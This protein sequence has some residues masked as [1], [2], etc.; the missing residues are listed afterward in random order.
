MQWGSTDRTNILLEAGADM[1]SEDN[2]GVPAI[3][4]AYQRDIREGGFG[5]EED[6][7]K[8]FLCLFVLAVRPLNLQDE[9][10]KAIYRAEVNAQDAT[11]MSPLHWAA[12][13]R[14]VSAVSVLLSAGAYVDIRSKR[15]KTPLFE[16]C[17]SNSK[18]CAELLLSY[19]ADVNARYKLGHAPIHA[20]AM[21]NSSRGLLE[22]LLSNGAD[23][24]DSQ[25]TC[26]TTPLN[27]AA[28][29]DH[30]R[31]C[32]HLLELGA[33]IENQDWLGETPLHETVS[34]NRHACLPLLL[35]RRP[36]Y[37]H[38]RSGDQTLLHVAAIK[39]DERT[40][41]IL[42][43]ANLK[44]LDPH[45]KDSRGMNARQY[46]AARSDPLPET[47]DSF[48][49]LIESLLRRNAEGDEN[50]LALERSDDEQF[51]DALERLC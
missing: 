21:G 47:K 17:F 19:G 24:N 6:K 27:E 12:T 14:D 7:I 40:F 22:L 32:E 39:A 11:G 50:S 2:F 29:C 33:D 25:N 30:S 43:A 20:A 51:V 15:D 4:D 1:F 28:S 16:A 49:A 9:L 18:E 44:G 8:R 23:V 41:K 31:C 46:F 36:N 38:R 5:P 34:L 26:R 3:L 42:S 13:R 48:E 10:D 35:S 37:L 45:A